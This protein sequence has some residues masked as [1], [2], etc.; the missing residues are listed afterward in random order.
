[1]AGQIS[2]SDQETDHRR[3]TLDSV[4]IMKRLILRWLTVAMCLILFVGCSC[5]KPSAEAYAAADARPW[6]GE[7]K[8]AQADQYPGAGLIVDLLNMLK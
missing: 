3:I 6:G 2:G 4:H 7:A 8:S 5:L 1:M